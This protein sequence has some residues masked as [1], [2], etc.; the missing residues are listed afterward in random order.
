LKLIE[1]NTGEA[2]RGNV[3]GTFLN[4][5]LIAQKIR[6]RVDK[7][8][9]IKIK[10]FCTAKETIIRMKRQSTEWD[11]IFSSY[12]SDKRLISRIYS[13]PKLNTKRTQSNG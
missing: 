12:L 3:G 11:K 8:D 2:T 4:R 10:R 6:A 5:T 1:E 13:G 9:C 7:W